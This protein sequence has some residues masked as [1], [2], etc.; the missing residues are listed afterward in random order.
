MVQQVIRYPY[1]TLSSRYRRPNRLF[2]YLHRSDTRQSLIPPI[3]THANVAHVGGC[4]DFRLLSSTHHQ[5]SSR[6]SPLVRHSQALYAAA[7]ISA[8]SC[9]PVGLGGML[10][11]AVAGVGAGA[12]AEAE[13]AFSAGL[14]GT[15]GFAGGAVGV[16]VGFFSSLAFEAG[17]STFTKSSFSL[18]FPTLKK[19]YTRGISHL[20][21]GAVGLLTSPMRPTATTR[22]ARFSAVTLAS[23]RI[24]SQVSLTTLSTSSLA[25]WEN[26][27]GKIENAF[28]AYLPQGPDT[29][30]G[31]L[32][33][34]LPHL[35]GW[36]S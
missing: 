25:P 15:G 12:G 19:A 9:S 26:V 1:I 7:W 30:L 20:C 27:S 21:Y 24:F 13:G 35:L 36:Q 33:F 18:S 8:F 22:S 29:L 34:E 16:D 2:Q 5:P 6:L 10:G 17:V 32:L 31:G 4:C 11:G 28:R 3:P 14:G 23:E